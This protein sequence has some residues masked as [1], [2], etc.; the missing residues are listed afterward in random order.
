MRAG[1]LKERFRFERRRDTSPDGG[2]GLGT[3]EGDW[4]PQFTVSA[5]LQFRRGGEDVLAA[6]LAGTQPAILTIR[7]SRQ[8]WEIRPDWRCVNDRTG[9]AFNIREEPTLNRDRDGLEMLIERGVNS[10]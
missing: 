8:A 2:D 6:R 5:K 3:F 10:G 7:V 1:E 9:E 4:E